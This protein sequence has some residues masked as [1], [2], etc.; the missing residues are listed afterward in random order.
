M[1][2]ELLYA[3]L[4]LTGGKF[5]ETVQLSYRDNAIYCFMSC[6]IDA[7]DTASS[8]VIIKPKNMQRPNKVDLRD[9]RQRK[10]E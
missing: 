6:Y 3:L 4:D 7:H 2:R 10:Y 1:P 9:R 5:I 8:L